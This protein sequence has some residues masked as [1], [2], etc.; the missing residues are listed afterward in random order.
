MQTITRE[1][2]RRELDAPSNPLV[3]DVLPAKDFRDFHLPSAINVPFGPQFD[4]QIQRAVP[5]KH[6]RVVVYCRDQECTASEK[7]ATAMEQAGY[8]DVS[9]YQAGKED[10]KRAGL[11]T[12]HAP[13]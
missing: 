4:Q 2:L 10:W 9:R 11:P 7:A 5:D 13:S 3:V 1:Q 6:R 12:E 8:T